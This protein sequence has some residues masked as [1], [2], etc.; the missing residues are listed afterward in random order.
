M[1]GNFNIAKSI[2]NGMQL[3]EIEFESNMVDE[4]KINHTFES[5]ND[6]LKFNWQKVISVW[7]DTFAFVIILVSGTFVI[8]SKAS[9]LV[10]VHLIHN[11]LCLVTFE[12]F[13]W[14]L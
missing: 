9:L 4:P 5:K 7:C 8:I 12:Y 1:K 10:L 11:S 3:K 13:V 2:L 14:L 6:V